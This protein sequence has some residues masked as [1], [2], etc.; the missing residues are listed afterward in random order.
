MILLMAFLVSFMYLIVALL[1]QQVIIND[2]LKRVSTS[3]NSCRESLISAYNDYMLNFTKIVGTSEFTTI[4]SSIEKQSQPISQINMGLQES[5]ISLSTFGSFVDTVY[6]TDRYDN[7]YR[8]F[9]T[10][11]KDTSALFF[12]EP[13]QINGIT[14]F[15]ARKNP[16]LPGNDVVP[17]VI[18]LTIFSFNYTVI[19]QD[20]SEAIAFLTIFIDAS[21]LNS[22]LHFWYNNFESSSLYLMDVNGNLMNVS[23]SILEDITK[24][25]TENQVQQYLT[26]AFTTNITTQYRLSN[27]YMTVSPLSDH[28][29]L[30]NITPL[31]SLNSLFSNLKRYILFIILAV[32]LFTTVVT[33]LISHFVSEPI[34]K[35][36]HIV[37]KIKNNTYKELSIPHSKDEV[38]QL[39]SAINDMYLTIQEQ[40]KH[41]KYSERQKY[42][43]EIALLA[44]QIN[45]HLL[46]NALEFINMEIY[47]GHTKEASGMVQSLADYMRISLSYGSEKISLSQELAQIRAYIN[48]MNYRFHNSILLLSYLPTELEE[49]QILKTILQPFIENSIKHGFSVGNE[50]QM[51]IHPTIEIYFSKKEDQL[52]IQITDNGIGFDSNELYSLLHDQQ[53][54]ESRRHVGLRNV[55][56]R[57]EACYSSVDIQLSSIPY[58]K[59]TIAI[60]LPYEAD[61]AITEVPHE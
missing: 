48:I 49:Y 40:I 2:S 59:N 56:Q 5:M 37:R 35:L 52:F 26:Q 41:I 16:F 24:T 4:L 13:E 39:N 14:F 23:P 15:P 17:V 19:A 33:L 36:A 54:T 28:L 29:A 8:C 57:L 31:D 27:D 10:Y 34:A 11:S 60:H 42:R 46:Y 45:P 47:S 22:S 32:L 38:G 55:M 6:I 50:P 20:S 7:V 18:P 12:Y 53:P 51:M 43:A 3:N 30:V 44:E 21:T 9:G 61:A 1:F 58:Y 25:I